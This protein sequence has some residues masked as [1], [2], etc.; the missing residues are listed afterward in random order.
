MLVAAPLLT[1]A[2]A[3]V[4]EGRGLSVWEQVFTGRIARN[5]LWLPLGNTLV[6]GIVVALGTVALGG[7]LAWL[8]VL[9]DVP[10]RRTIGVF[11]TLPYMIPSFA[12]AFAWG[13]V[14]RNE[15]VGGQVGIL[16]ELG[17]AV[18]DWLAWGMVPTLL[19]LVAH[20][21]SLA[22]LLIAAALASIN[23]DLIE[24]GTMTGA[25]PGRI[26]IGITLPIVI[27]AIL[28]A[29]SLA[30]AGAVSNFA[31]PAILGLPVGMQ[32]LSTRL[33]GAIS[34]G[35]VER[36]YVLAI[37]LIAVA[38]LVLWA[39]NR[40]MSGRRS[41]ATISGKGG[42]NRRFALGRWRWP[43]LG[44]AAA[45]LALTTVMPL[46]ALL[47]SSVTIRTGDIFSGFT[48]HFWIGGSNPDY[49]QGQAGILRN[50]ETLYAIGITLAFAGSVAVVSMGL[51]LAI[52]YAVSRLKRHPVG[53]VLNQLAF[54]PALVPGIAFGAAYIALF[55]A[56]I[57]PFPALYGTFALLVIAGAAYT[58]PFTVQSGR[59]AMEQV[60]GELEDSAS[61]TGAGFPRRLLAIFLPLTARSLMAGGVLTFVKI[62]RDL[63]LVVLLFT[64]ATPVLSVLAYRYASEGFLQF[65]NAITAL[66]TAVALASTLLAQRL[67]GKAEPWLDEDRKETR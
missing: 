1:V 54:L 17:V 41:F 29:G 37:V 18:P 47:L 60:A 28:S 49:A 39:S 30:F 24:A 3:T 26:L 36:G 7:F 52:A 63:S 6:I 19:V 34:T 44:L 53:A 46:L 51:G 38:A 20:Y 55:G 65:G 32:T 59:A 40:I 2:L 27:P 56:P 10:F 25:R 33:Y 67:Q 11:A 23:A 4:G 61:M 64:P 48:L 21:Y 8:V 22:F 45:I 5:F 13:V 15:R 57:G 16:S 58:L 35:Q 14:F 12:A 9:T 31:A 43:L 62:L 42:R 66:I 50:P